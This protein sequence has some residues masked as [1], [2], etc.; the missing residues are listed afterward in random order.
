MIVYTLKITLEFSSCTFFNSSLFSFYLETKSSLNVILLFIFFCIVWFNRSRMWKK[1]KNKKRL[2][3]FHAR[4]PVCLVFFIIFFCCCFK[5]FFFLN[6]KVE[7]W[8]F[9]D[10]I[11]KMLCVFCFKLFQLFC[12][13]YFFLHFCLLHV[14]NHQNFV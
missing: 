10:L 12:C 3:V 13:Y 1:K 2:I 8:A 11:E 9:F 14:C 4:R 7:R 6:M 5:T